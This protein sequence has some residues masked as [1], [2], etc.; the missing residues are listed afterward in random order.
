MEEF[1]FI[2]NEF[3]ELIQWEGRL[4]EFQLQENEFVHAMTGFS[5]KGRTSTTRLAQEERNNWICADFA[6]QIG[7]V[8][9]LRTKEV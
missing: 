4:E 7:Q 1:E 8:I 6:I 2:E 5:P 3:V 9:I